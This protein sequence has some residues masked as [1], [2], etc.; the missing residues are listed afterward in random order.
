MRSQGAVFEQKARAFLETKGL[1]YVAQNQ[2]FKCGELDLVMQEGKT[3]VFVEVRQRKNTQFGSAL[4]SINAAKQ[5]KWLKAANLWLY[6]RGQSLDTADCRFDV[7]VF[8][9]NQ[10]P[11]WIKNFLG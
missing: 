4:E 1:S 11:L 5:Q 3:L 8:E 6:E 9:G 7:V 10:P 2:A